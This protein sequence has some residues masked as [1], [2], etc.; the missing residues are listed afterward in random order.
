[1]KEEEYIILDK[2]VSKAVGYLMKEAM[3]NDGIYLNKIDITDDSHL[4]LIYLSAMSAALADKPFAMK[5]G[6]FDY[7][8]FKN[9]FKKRIN[10]KRKINSIKID[11]DVVLQ[12]IIDSIKPIEV[13][14]EKDIFSI[15][16]KEYYEPKDN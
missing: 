6:L 10:F 5:L 15:I 16:Y 7:I 2:V 14:S 9:R 8:K 4:C 3:D 11:C 1:M 13:F 12:E